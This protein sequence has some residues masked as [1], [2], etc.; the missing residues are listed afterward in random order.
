MG[1]LEQD[2]VVDSQLHVDSSASGL[3]NKHNRELEHLSLTNQPLK[4]VKFFVLAVLKCLQEFSVNS[5]VKCSCL[6]VMLLAAA[7]G[8][9]FFRSGRAYEEPVQE[10]LSYLR[11]GLWWLALGVASSIGLG[12]GLHTFVLYLGPHIALFTIKSVSCGRVDIKSAPYDTIQLRSGP[13]WLDKDCSEFGPPLF[14]SGARVPLTS[15]L[16]QVQLE[17]ILWGIG[18]ALGELPPYFISRAAHISGSEGELMEDLDSG[19]KEDSGII[20][21]HLKQIKQWLLSNRQYLNFFTILVLASVPNPL[22]DL[23]GIMCGQFGIPFWKFFI[24]TLIGK[25]IIKTHIQTAFIISVC[26]NQLLDLIENQLVRVLGLIPGV[27]SLMPNIISKLH[28]AREKYMA[29]SPPVSNVKAKKWDFS[30][31]SVW[32]TVVWLMLLNFS[33]KIVNTTAKSYLREQQEK[34]LAALE[35]NHTRG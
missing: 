3:L 17:A 31:G 22:F 25:A 28:V 9:L 1:S 18:T 8:I 15:I 20:S 32:N 34:E 13:S 29:A 26:N 21:N 11:F 35:N 5:I 7:G 10:L 6:V 30:L 33:A 16:N 2:Q 27:A 24:A 4:T 23:A 12:S 19:S 14:S